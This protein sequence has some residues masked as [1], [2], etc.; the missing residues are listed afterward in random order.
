MYCMAPFTIK[1]TGV[2]EP[3]VW[4]LWGVVGGVMKFLSVQKET[5]LLLISV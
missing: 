4:G 3:A 2:L 5:L 1:V